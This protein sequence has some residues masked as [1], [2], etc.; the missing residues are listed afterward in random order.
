MNS[1]VTINGRTF[2][3]RYSDKDTGSLRT[4]ASRGA[5]LPVSLTIKH[6][7]IR[8]GSNTVRRSVLR[9][10]RVVDTGTS[11]LKTVSAY[12][13]VTCPADVVIANSDITASI[14]DLVSCLNGA[15]PTAGLDLIS[16]VF[17]TQEQ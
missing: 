14:S 2:A 6:K 11:G 5:N 9:V 15:T 16:P 13:V 4:D 3:L 1:N 10:D 7:D 12:C 17:L 8:E